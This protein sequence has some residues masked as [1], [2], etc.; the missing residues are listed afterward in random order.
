MFAAV[1]DAVPDGMRQRVL[2]GSQ[3][4]GVDE[5]GV[6]LALDSQ[7]RAK[8]GGQGLGQRSQPIE[9]RP[10]RRS[11]VDVLTQLSSPPSARS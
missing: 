1:V 9:E 8:A 3:E 4:A 2:Q 5:D 10:E 6:T 7:L 11:G